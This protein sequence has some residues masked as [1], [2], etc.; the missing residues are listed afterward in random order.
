MNTTDLLALTG[1]DDSEN[2]ETEKPG[3]LAALDP[4]ALHYI[5]TTENPDG[6]DSDSVR[7]AVGNG[8]HHPTGD[9]V[10]SYLVATLHV[11]DPTTN[12]GPIHRA[13][14]PTTRS[15]AAIGATSPVET[16][17]TTHKTEGE[18]PHSTGIS[19]YLTTGKP[20]D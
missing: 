16:D 6:T 13:F 15:N 12:R 5:E 4:E 3:E 14:F 17:V 9:T 8:P 10:R 18:D 1:K 7:C 11:C 20:T 2:A 19:E